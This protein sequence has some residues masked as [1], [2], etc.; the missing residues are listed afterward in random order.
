MATQMNGREQTNALAMLANPE[1]LNGIRVGDQVRLP[2]IAC[3]LEVVELAD[4]LLILRA[5]G[6]QTLKAGWRAVQKIRTRKDIS[7]GGA[8]AWTKQQR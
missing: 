4:P 6:G 5:P 1:S 7:R 3:N 2:S 8:K